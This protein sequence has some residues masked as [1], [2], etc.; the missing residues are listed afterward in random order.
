VIGADGSA[1]SY[2]W[3]YAATR[4]IVEEVASRHGWQVKVVL[5]KNSAQW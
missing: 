5:T 3:D 4:Q 2:E 1:N